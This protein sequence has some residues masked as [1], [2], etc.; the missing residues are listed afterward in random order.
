MLKKQQLL[1]I[2]QDTKEA[3]TSRD[4]EDFRI[5]RMEIPMKANIKKLE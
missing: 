5:S 4:Y 1:E 2:R 3:T